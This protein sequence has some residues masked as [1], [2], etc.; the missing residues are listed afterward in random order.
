MSLNKPIT[1]RF[2]IHKTEQGH[3][4]ICKSWRFPVRKSLV[5]ISADKPTVSGGVLTHLSLE[6]KT[7]GAA[8]QLRSPSFSQCQCIS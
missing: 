1:N 4:C 8:I 6:L 3:R 5:L 2:S 7:D